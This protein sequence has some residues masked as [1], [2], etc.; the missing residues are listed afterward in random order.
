MTNLMKNPAV[1]AG[2]LGVAVLV[3]ALFYP[4]AGSARF[5]PDPNLVERGKYVVTLGGCNDC[6]TPGYPE[7]GGTTPVADWLTG[8][9]VGYKGP[10][11]VSYATNLRRSFDDMSEDEWVQRAGSMQ[12]LPPMPWFA[13]RDMNEAD[14]RAVYHFV[15]SLGV[16]G[17]PAPAVIGPDEEVTTPY[18]LFVPQNMEALGSQ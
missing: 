3:A 9:P 4:Q 12:A 18:I 13:L 1:L 15:K 8:S 17:E 5:T 11:G 6:H 2:A 7:N 10:W 14:R 16:K